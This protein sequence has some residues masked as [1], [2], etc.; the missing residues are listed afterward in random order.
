MTPR[1]LLATLI[2]LAAPLI[3][4]VTRLLLHDRMPDP[5][6]THWDLRGRV[7]GTTG[8]AV[9]TTV[10]LVVTAL[11]AL[12]G[13]AAL[14]L[15]RNRAQSAASTLLGW[16]GW[17]FAMLYAGTLIASVDVEKAA[18]VDLAWW[19]LVVTLAVPVL[20]GLV[21]F[22][23]LPP[24]EPAPVRPGTSMPLADD[25]RVAWFGSARSVAMASAG[26]VVAVIGAVVLFFEPL[27][28][29]LIVVVGAL[30]WWMHVLTVRV[31][32]RGVRA[33]WGPTGWPGRT[34]PLTAVAGAESIDL[35]PAQWGGWGYR[36]ST[37]GT[38][39]VVRRGPAVV[40]HR[41]GATD[42]AITVD[43]AD[44]AAALVN[45]LVQRAD[46]RA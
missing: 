6:P 25:E 18:D 35:E 17:L 13:T 31:D 43:G 2:L 5:M 38:A 21:L 20:V 45:A 26:A 39:F 8:F 28:G 4:L 27:A 46:A 10:V 9:F 23:L 29:V 42:L 16:L 32:G 24:Q 36:L 3:V 37:R 15:A 30:L 14:W 41:R 7:D 19:L 12:A 44:E 22:R 40:L 1:R 11:A 34:V 33:T